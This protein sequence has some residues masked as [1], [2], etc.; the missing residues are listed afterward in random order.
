MHCIKDFK[1]PLLQSIIVNDDDKL[2]CFNNKGVYNWVLY[3]QDLQVNKAMHNV[4]RS[5]EY[6]N[7]KEFLFDPRQQPRNFDIAQFHSA[8]ISESFSVS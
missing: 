1:K 8:K 4:T 6:W 5:M 3:K 2:F 7:H